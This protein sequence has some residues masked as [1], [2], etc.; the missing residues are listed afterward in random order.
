VLRTGNESRSASEPAARGS[1]TSS[2]NGPS[3]GRPTC[4]GRGHGSV[5][6]TARYLHHLG[7]FAHHPALQLPD[8]TGAR[9]L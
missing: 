9:A 7:D 5:E 3:A 6:V 2:G 4:G 1:S 8:D